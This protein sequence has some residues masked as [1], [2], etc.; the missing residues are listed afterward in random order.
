[1]RES[2]VAKNVRGRVTA[3]ALAGLV[4][5]LGVR[6]A[7]TAYWPMNASGS[8]NAR[9]VED[10]LGRHD[11][12]VRAAAYGAPAFLDN[13][14]GWTLPPNRDAAGGES[15]QMLVSSVG[16]KA[17]DGNGKYRPVLSNGKG[18]PWAVSAFHD[19][20]IEGWLRPTAL[21]ASGGKW[22]IVFNTLGSAGGWAWQFLP[23]DANGCCPF[24]IDYNYNGNRVIVDLKTSVAKDELLNRWNHYAITL[25]ARVGDAKCEWRFYVNGHLRGSAQANSADSS[26][27]EWPSGSFNFSGCSSSTAQQIA[28]QMTCW[29]ASDRALGPGEFLCDGA[30]RGT[31]VAYWPMNLVMA[32]GSRLVPSATSEDTD[33]VV[34]NAATGGFSFEA[35][36]I[37]WTTPPNLGDETNDFTGV[38]A[39]AS[40][41]VSA[42]GSR[43]GSTYQPLLS[44]KNAALVS[45]LTPTNDF[46]VEG[47]YRA[48]TLPADS[49]KNY[50]FAYNTLAEKGGWLWS[51]LGPNA[52]GMCSI[53]VGVNTGNARETLTLT[54]KLDPAELLDRWNHYALVYDTAQNMWKFYLNGV[55]RGQAGK[56]RVTGVAFAPDGMIV[57]L[58]GISSGMNP[59]SLVGDLST[60]RVS[61]AALRSGQFLCDDPASSPVNQLV[62][63]GAESAVWSTE[64]ILNWKDARGEATAWQNGRDAVIDE[65]STT[66]QI[67]L[68][69]AVSPET[70][71]VDI[72]RDVTIKVSAQ[73]YIAQGCT[74]FE[75]SGAGTLWL[76]GGAG[77]NVN[78]SANTTHVR[79]GT[80]RVSSPNGPRALGDATIGYHAFVH[81]GGRLW[82][83]QRNA[84]G[85][86]GSSGINVNNSHV[87]VYTNGVFDLTHPSGT[88]NI[89][90]VG[91]LDLLGGRLAMPATG[92][93]SGALQIRERVE[94]GTNPTREPYVFSAGGFDGAVEDTWA[95]QI[96]TNT[97]FRVADITEDAA[98]D[99]VFNNHVMVLK[100]WNDA[101]PCGFRKT[102]G[103]TMALAQ[104]PTGYGVGLLTFPSG[105]IAVEEGELRVDCEYPGPAFAVAPRAFLSGTGTVSAVSFAAGAGLRGVVGQAGALTIADACAFAEEGT[106]SLR[107]PEGRG[108]FRT[109]LA[110]LAGTCSGVENLENWTV[111]VNGVAMKNLAV[112]VLGSNLVVYGRFGTSIIIR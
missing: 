3:L 109:K 59:Q 94:F 5:P 91:R 65:T 19:F 26:A 88:F 63:T 76:S 104:Q 8:E 49:T 90:S 45:T 9:V 17:S 105:T 54:N 43:L 22:L 56:T 28:G 57:G 30:N 75:K 44:N 18:L 39:S 58:S 99:V 21:P 103:G 70:F 52:N 13:D 84:M 61:R 100:T 60:W 33:L 79:A 51:L 71:T 24:K 111:L 67:T 96:G 53:Q 110:T 29:R 81:D 62:W 15:L 92:H 23:P 50:V 14:I 85:P 72:D 20:T 4:A 41:L 12:A 107:N 48:T 42:S 97:E 87:T 77:V 37:G 112:G 80:L 16:V 101:V 35:N 46:C 64:T 74:L 25:T 86:S 34:R 95:W 68:G 27:G 11:L 38:W 83:D 98:S 7:T 40:R 6:A 69:G 36:D 108:G 10:A 82:I 73:G 47:W 32:G 106:V 102:G 1:M 55:N 89:Q 93:G 31:T 66:T 78:R 2:A